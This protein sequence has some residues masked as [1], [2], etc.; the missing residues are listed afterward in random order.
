MLVFNNTCIL[1]L[2]SVLHYIF[3]FVIIITVNIELFLFF[4][5]LRRYNVMVSGVFVW[6]RCDS[7]ACPGN[8]L[9]FVLYSGISFCF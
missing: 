1:W 6:I 7:V 9:L 2:F 5:F 4:L 8:C 3:F